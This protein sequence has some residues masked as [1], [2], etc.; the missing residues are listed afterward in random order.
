MELKALTKFII[1]LSILCI[2]ILHTICV[3]GIDSSPIGP[4]NSMVGFSTLNYYFFQLIQVNFTLYNITDWCGLIPLIIGMIYAT[5]GLIQWIKRK[6]ILNVDSNILALGIFYILVIAVYLFFEYVVINRR[7]VLINGYLEASY[8]SSTTL[9]ALCFMVTSIDQTNR[10]LRNT[11]MKKV[12]IILSY[13]F[14][15]FMVGGRTISG[16]HWLSDIIGG[17]MISVSLIYFYFGLKSLFTRLQ[18]N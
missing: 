2:F 16:V 8:P 18:K 4:N 12:I 7:P 11:K 9:L 17:I 3:K 5:M 1:S 14:I 15:I 13:C 10:Y 6:R